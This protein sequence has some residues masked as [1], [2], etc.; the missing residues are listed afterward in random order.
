MVILRD[1]SEDEMILAFL[2]SETDS[3]RFGARLAEVREKRGISENIIRSGDISSAEENSL[4]AGLLG[5]FR[6]YPDREIFENYPEDVSWKYV[7]FD[8]DDLGRL[9]Y[10]DYS[11]WNE[12]SEGTSKPSVAAETIR[13]GIEIY[14]QPNRNFL[15]G[16]G[17]LD[18]GG[19][20]PPLIVLICG[21]EKYIIIEGHCRAT[22]YALRPDKFSG[23]HGYAG[24]CSSDIRK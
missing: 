5:E 8:A 3:K 23:T 2:K 1:S 18:G 6:G 19:S 10:V 14:G 9:R 11:Y 17:F 4:R 12:L 21:D 13:K 16:A 22:S 20:F 7:R 24:F 15:D